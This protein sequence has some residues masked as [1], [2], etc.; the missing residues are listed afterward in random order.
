MPLAARTG[1]TL[2]GPFFIQ[3]ADAAPPDVKRA[4][5]LWAKEIGC[6]SGD[7]REAHAVD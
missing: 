1:V 6:N 2:N 3:W 5:I 7:L 4:G